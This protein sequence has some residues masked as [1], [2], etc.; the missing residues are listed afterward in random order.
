MDI[1]ELID[2]GKKAKENSS[3]DIIGQ[4]IC[5]NEECYKWSSTACRFLEQ[6]YPKDKDTSRFQYLVNE[7]RTSLDSEYIFDEMIGILEA[8]KTIKTTKKDMD[9]ENIIYKIC[10][11][12]NRF[13]TNI[14]RRYNGRVTLEINDEYDLQDSLLAILKLFIEDIRKEDYVPS[15]GGG[16]SRVDFFIPDLKTAIE[17]KMTNKHL[18]D[19]EIGDQLLIDIGRYRGNPEIKKVIFFIYDKNTFISNVYGIINDI[20]KMSTDELEIKVYISPN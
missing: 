5:K 18:K 7:L 9:I 1:K 17:T 10:N 16:N 15:Y 4:K 6:Y 12:F 11:N 14:K 13:D 2:L 19:K 20:E 8:V 3:C